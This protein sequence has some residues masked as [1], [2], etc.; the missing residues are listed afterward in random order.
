MEEAEEVQQEAEGADLLGPR[1]VAP[2]E[3][4]STTH[5]LGQVER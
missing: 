4:Q 2:C 3:K 1:S 5:S